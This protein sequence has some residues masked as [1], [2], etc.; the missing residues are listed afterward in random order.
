MWRVA[1][2]CPFFLSKYAYLTLFLEALL[3]GPEHKNLFRVKMKTCIFCHP[4]LIFANLT[5]FCYKNAGVY[6]LKNTATFI[7]NSLFSLSRGGACQM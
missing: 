6:L 3:T 2:V 7:K 1:R 5:A 4:E